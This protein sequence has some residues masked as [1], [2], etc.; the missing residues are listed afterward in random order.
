MSVAHTPDSPQ[1]TGDMQK[2]AKKI[3]KKDMADAKLRIT[4][5]VGEGKKD[6]APTIAM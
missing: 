5:G 1:H 2:T 3:S 4:G 6:G